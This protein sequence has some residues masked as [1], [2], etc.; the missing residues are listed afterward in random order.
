VRALFL[1]NSIAETEPKPINYSL[2]A[3]VLIGAFFHNFSDGILLGTA[4][5]L[6]HRELALTILVA[7]IYHEIAQEIADFYL[8]TKHCNIKV[9]MALCLNFLGG[10]SVMIGAI[11]IISFNI[12]T[13]VTGC[14]LALGSGVYMYIAAAKCYPQAKASQRTMAD[15]LL[16]LAAWSVGVVPIGLVL[17]NHEHC[18]A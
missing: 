3:S 11:F 9:P 2:A 7:T 6:C 17:L 16:S 4:F 8:L 12:N 5:S 18:K 14:V 1:D 15:K 10:L 13:M